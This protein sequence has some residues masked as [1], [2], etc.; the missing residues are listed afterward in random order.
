MSPQKQGFF[1]ICVDF[2]GLGVLKAPP[3]KPLF[4]SQIR[5]NK[6]EPGDGIEPTTY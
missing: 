6:V 4:I 3:H 5:L 2:V 1:W